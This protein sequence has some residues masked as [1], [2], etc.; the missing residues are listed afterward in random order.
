[1]LVARAGGGRAPARLT[2]LRLAD[3]VWGAA[4]GSADVEAMGGAP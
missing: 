1:M 3:S 2:Y 4:G